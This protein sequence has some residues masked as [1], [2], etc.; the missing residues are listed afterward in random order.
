MEGR[1]DERILCRLR[2]GMTPLG[3]QIARLLQP[4]H[5]EDW[6]LWF[7]MLHRPT[8]L[9]IDVSLF[10]VYVARMELGLWDRVML[11]PAANRLRRHLERQ[12]RNEAVAELQGRLMTAEERAIEELMRS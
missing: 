8:R 5:W 1:S 7:G 6:C 3:Q 12:R 11:W 10:D 9:L 2:M 4:E